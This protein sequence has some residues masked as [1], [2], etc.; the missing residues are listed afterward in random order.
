MLSLDVRHVGH[1]SP[2]DQQ[3]RQS[4]HQWLHKLDSSLS[5]VQN[6]EHHHTMHLPLACLTC[7]KSFAPRL[8]NSPSNR[9]PYSTEQASIISTDWRRYPFSC[10][11]YQVCVVARNLQASILVVQI[12][13]VL[14]VEA[15]YYRL[16]CPCYQSWLQLWSCCWWTLRKR[17]VQE[18][19][20]RCWRK[21]KT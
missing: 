19:P 10:Q 4:K 15:A 3:K 5:Y 17:L 2:R 20:Q 1:A 9:R 18:T 7:R 12:A 11:P 6:T 13:A 21:K 16:A 14:A 8:E